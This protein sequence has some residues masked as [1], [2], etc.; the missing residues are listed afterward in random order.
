MSSVETINY[1]DF[2]R[3]LSER[4]YYDSLGES[5]KPT[6]QGCIDLNEGQGGE[7]QMAHMYPGGCLYYSSEYNFDLDYDTQ[8]EL[9]TKNIEDTNSTNKYLL[10]NKNKIENKNDFVVKNKGRFTVY[11]ETIDITREELEKKDDNDRLMKYESFI[12]DAYAVKPH[13]LK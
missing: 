13:S 9:E 8:D 6:C 2:D 4:T 1:T 7:N 10:A 5:N 3:E 11:Y 12:A